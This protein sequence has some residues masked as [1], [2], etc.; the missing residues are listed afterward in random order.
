MT[1]LTLN[2]LEMV[3]V[4]LS[5]INPPDNVPKIPQMM[6]IPPNNKSASLWQ[7]F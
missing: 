1:E 5:R 4:I 2:E 6:V 7:E 3:A